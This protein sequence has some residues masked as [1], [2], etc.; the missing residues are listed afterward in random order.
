MNSKKKL[1]EFYQTCVSQGVSDIGNDYQQA[2]AEQIAKSINIDLSK[3]LKYTYFNAQAQAL[4]N[5][6]EKKI[7]AQKAAEKKQIAQQKSYAKAEAKW[8]QRNNK[9]Y[10]KKV[11][12]FSKYS[13]LYGN[14]KPIQ[15]IEDEYDKLIKESAVKAANLE[16]E[17]R[18]LNLYSRQYLT[19]EMERDWATLAGVANGIAGPAAGLATALEVQRENEAIRA[20]NAA[21]MDVRVQMYMNSLN[22]KSDLKSIAEKARLDV[23]KAIQEKEAILNKLKLKIVG[24]A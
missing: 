16:Q 23:Q 6:E 8:E 2:K 24:I 3:G 22:N 17:L 20:R 13:D 21:T 4:E 11:E 18:D 19:G 5:S 10:Q 15:M 9:A 1:I 12:N 14:D 7:K